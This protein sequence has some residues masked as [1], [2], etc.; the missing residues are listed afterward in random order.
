M[1]VVARP[2]SATE[3]PLGHAS[4]NVCARNLSRKRLESVVGQNRKSSMRAYVFRLAPESRHHLTHAVCPF[5]ANKRLMH[6]GNCQA[7]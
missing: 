4:K 2:R 3:S 5:R 7:V 6:C 1:A